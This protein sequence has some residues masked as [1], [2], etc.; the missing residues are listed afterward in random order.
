MP[1]IIGF[2]ILNL[3]PSKIQPISLHE[4]VLCMTIL[5]FNTCTF[6]NNYHIKIKYIKYSRHKIP[7]KRERCRH[8]R[9]TI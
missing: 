8:N 6:F 2:I 4:Y 3:I 5:S 7:V 1:T 9:S